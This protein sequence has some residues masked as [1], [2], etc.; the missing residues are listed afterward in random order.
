M[1][2]K[3]PG[4]IDLSKEERR[5]I[6]NMIM[7]EEKISDAHYK[8]LVIEA[9]QFIEKLIEDLKS[10]R[11]TLNQLKERLLGFK[12]ERRKKEEQPH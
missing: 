9:L 2:I 5:A 3:K 10:S 6:L 4:I 1:A 7:S 11:I 8:E 12:S